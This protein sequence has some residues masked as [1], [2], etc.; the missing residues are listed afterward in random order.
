MG[1]RSRDRRLAR[2]MDLAMNKDTWVP[3][4]VMVSLG[5]LTAFDGVAIARAA[6]ET[7]RA[8]PTSMQQIELS[9]AEVVRKAAPAVVNIYSKRIVRSA[10]SDDALFKKFFGSGGGRERVQSALGSGAFVRAHWIIVSH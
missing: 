1:L 4:W 7:T 8:V 6:E 3:A 10:F 9:F 2:H 5:L